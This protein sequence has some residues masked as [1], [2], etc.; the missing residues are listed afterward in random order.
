MSPEVLG[1]RALNR[2]LLERQ[3][4][5]RRGRMPAAAAIE[6]L[7][8]MQAQVPTS[9][10]S[11]LWSRLESFR[12][13]EL[14]GLITGR[15]AVRTSL[16]RTT[17][18][19]VT[20]AD[21]LA[22][23]PLLE[24]VLLRGFH[25][26]SPFGR[27]LTGVDLDAV[28]AAGVALLEERPRSVA[29]LGALLAERWPGRDATSLGYAV[30]LLVPV[31][32]VPPRGVWGSAG[33]ARLAPVAR[34]LTGVEAPP[35]R[36]EDLVLR[37]LG[38]FGPASVRD[39]QAWCWLTRLAPV[40]ERL[41]PRLRVFRDEA[42]VELF[43]LPEAPRPDPDTPAPPRFVPEYDNLLLSH[44]DRSRVIAPQHRER[45]FTR[46]ALLV[47]GLV[48]GAWRVRRA[49]DTATLELELFAPL[50]GADAAAVTAEGERLLDFLAG[51][52]ATRE[53]RTV[54]R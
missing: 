16:M 17:L 52:A 10:Y 48:H 53:L 37:Y 30:R 7:V 34:W 33:Q 8:G 1:P 39:V 15:G 36:L 25:T 44:S 51:D 9:P 18:H 42:G 49:R 19:L 13:E 43:D 5:L 6:H 26:G 38:A 4:L 35:L 50:H 41:R 11:G 32:Q 54:A 12:H 27:Q 28:V 46:G 45:I 24:P 40:L 20:A 3:L 23:R 31:V 29:E 2:A 22:L 14:A 21:A 47:D